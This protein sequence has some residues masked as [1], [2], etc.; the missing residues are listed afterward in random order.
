MSDAAV[1]HRSL[2]EIS[3]TLENIISFKTKSPAARRKVCI[4][5]AC[6]RAIA[7]QRFVKSGII[8][9]NHGESALYGRCTILIF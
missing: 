1:S 7:F 8:E 4:D 3:D 2:Y 6:T 9:S 5:R